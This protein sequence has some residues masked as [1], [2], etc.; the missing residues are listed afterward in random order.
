MPKLLNSLAISSVCQPAP[1]IIKTAW[2]PFS[3]ALDICSKWFVF[4]PLW[5]KELLWLHQFLFLGIP[6]QANSRIQIAVF[7]HTRPGS[8]SPQRRVVVFCWPNLASSWNQAS[9]L[10]S[11]ILSGAFLFWFFK[12]ILDFLWFFGVWND[13]FSKIRPCGRGDNRQNSGGSTYQRFSRFSHLYRRYKN[14]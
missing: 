5:P 3:L 8:T 2:R 4:M 6:N 7:Y 11:P 14:A 9:T 1:S 12:I 10:Y 13:K